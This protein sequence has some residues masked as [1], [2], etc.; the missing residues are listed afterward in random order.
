[1]DELEALRRV[2]PKG[3]RAHRAPALAVPVTGP[4]F[5]DMEGP[6]AVR[7][8]V[9]VAAIA[10]RPHIGPTVE[11]DEPLVLVASA[12]GLPP[13][14]NQRLTRKAGFRSLS[15]RRRG[16]RA[17]RGEGP[18]RRRSA[19]GQRLLPVP[20]SPGLLASL[21][22]NLDRLCAFVPATVGRSAAPTGRCRPNV[23]GT[24]VVPWSDHQRS[25]LDQ[26]HHLLG[27]DRTDHHRPTGGGLSPNLRLVALLDV[28][29][30]E[31][32]ALGYGQVDDDPNVGVLIATMDDTAGW[33]AT[34]QLRGWERSQLSLRPGQ[35]L[36][37]VGCGLGD[38][39]LSLGEDLGAGGEVVGVD[40]SA[41]MIAGARGRADG[42]QCRVRFVVG[43][44]LALDE[45]TSRFDVVRSER[46]LQWLTDPETAV[47]EM[48]RVVRPGGLVSLLDTDW[49][50]FEVEVGDVELSQRVRDALRSERRRPSN[51]G[52]RLADVVRA[53]GLRPLAQTMATQTWDAWNPDESPAPDGCFSMASLAEDLVERGHLPARD[54]ERFVSTIHTAAREARFSMALTMFALVAVAPTTDA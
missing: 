30:D 14:S 10:Q 44:A 13:E 3:H 21:D 29:T 19:R 2:P 9:A 26:Q 36:L 23:T 17:S 24:G 49:S 41:A 12:D 28:G 25:S 46:C 1:M 45:S 40:A 54:R 52:R 43:D 51:I 34:Q 4:V 16:V 33:R 39:A 5:V 50:T 8:V 6:Q 31:T 32:H 35:R 15:P 48:A 27:D 18:I 42:A 53:V 20:A 47:A 22:P 38:A 7:A 11:A 37:D